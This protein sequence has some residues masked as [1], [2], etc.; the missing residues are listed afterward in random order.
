MLEGRQEGRRYLQSLRGD[1]PLSP[2][3]PATK[4]VDG[5]NSNLADAALK[6]FCLS[7]SLLIGHIHRI[8]LVLCL[9]SR[10]E[11]PGGVNGLAAVIAPS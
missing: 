9:P 4:A 7:I 1:F 11:P 5:D 3:H 10:K 6:C 8:R 2:L